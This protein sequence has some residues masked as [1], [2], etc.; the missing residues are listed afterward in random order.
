[1]IAEGNRVSLLLNGSD[2]Q[3][4]VDNPYDAEKQTRLDLFTS[5]KG[6]GWATTHVVKPEMEST[7]PKPRTDARTQMQRHL[8]P[9]AVWAVQKDDLELLKIMIERG[10]K[11]NEPINF[12]E[13][14]TLLH[15][16][17]S[18]NNLKIG[19]FLLEKGADPDIRDRYG[20]LPIHSVIENENDPMAQLLSKPELEEMQIDGIPVG[21][22]EEVLSGSRHPGLIFVSLNEKDPTEEMLAEM[23]KTIPDVRPASKMKIVKIRPIGAHS[24]YRDTETGKFGDLIQV[25]LQKNENEWSVYFRESSGPSMAGGGWSGRAD[26]AYGYW[27]TS[28]DESWDE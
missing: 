28:T 3:G 8:S 15:S 27:Y 21:L 7:R 26:K 2:H 16:V 23:R 10:L 19:K 20:S 12:P 1:M 18:A 25:K 6:L 5:A 9:A 14:E 13:S 17:V 24:S 4:S 22:V 11:V